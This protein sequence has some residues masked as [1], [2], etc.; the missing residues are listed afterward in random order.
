MTREG[1]L[2]VEN[3]VTLAE[4]FRITAETNVVLT[5][6]AIDPPLERWW[7][8]GERRREAISQLR[9]LNI[10]LV[11]TPNY[12]LFTDQPRWDDLHSMKRIALV[13]QEF[14]EGGV[15]AALH[16]NARTDRDW[17]RWRDYINAR[18][19]I[20][21]IAFEFGTGAGWGSRIEWSVAQLMKLAS[22]LTRPVHLIIRGG[23]NKIAT[24]AGAYSELTYLD[25]TAFLKTI[26]RRRAVTTN[27]CGILWRR[28]TT[29]TAEPLDALFAENWSAVQ[30]WVNGQIG[31]IPE[32]KRAA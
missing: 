21:H 7:S 22:E 4:R 32:S 2:R 24:L 23:R 31:H 15:P 12:S 3:R 11:T 30:Q 5:G 13:H 8:L 27:E 19:E 20:S 6:T 28:Q 1:T 18:H 25:T 14:L 9:G 10:A 16:V 26:R 29:T 17:E